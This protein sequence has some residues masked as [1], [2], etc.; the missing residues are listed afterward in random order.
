[1][2]FLITGKVPKDPFCVSKHEM[3]RWK[4][5]HMRPPTFELGRNGKR[6]PH[7]DDDDDDDDDDDN[8]ESDD[9]RKHHRKVYLNVLVELHIF[10]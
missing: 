7:Y 10:L 2:L 8:D 5:K 3:R 1:M 9:D 6:K 4:H